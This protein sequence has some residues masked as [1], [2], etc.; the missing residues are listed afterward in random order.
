MSDGGFHGCIH[1]VLFIIESVLFW[2]LHIPLCLSF[3][4]IFLFIVIWMH[5]D[6]ACWDI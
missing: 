6:G 3:I 1:S 4:N 5:G 2:T